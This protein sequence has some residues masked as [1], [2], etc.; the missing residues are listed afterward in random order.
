[1]SPSES[2]KDRI[3]VGLMIEDLL[4]SHIPHHG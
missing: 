3:D 1:V 2:I 4:T